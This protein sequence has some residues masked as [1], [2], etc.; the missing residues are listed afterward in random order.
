M[1]AKMQYATGVGTPDALKGACP[2]WGRA[3]MKPTAARQQGASFDSHS[4]IGHKSTIVASHAGIDSNAQT[5]LHSTGRYELR[6]FPSVKPPKNSRCLER[7]FKPGIGGT[8]PWIRVPTS[9]T[10]FRVVPAWR[11]YTDS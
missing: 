1:N 7:L 8:T 2:V 3:G 11:S 6:A 5:S 4:K 10:S 9:P